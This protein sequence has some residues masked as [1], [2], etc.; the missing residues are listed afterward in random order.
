MVLHLDRQ[1]LM[2]YEQRLKESEMF[3]DI[4]MPISNFEKKKNIDFT[5]YCLVDQDQLKQVE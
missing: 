5:M 3:S 4:R 2:D 1:T